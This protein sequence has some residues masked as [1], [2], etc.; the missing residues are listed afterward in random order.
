MS[1]LFQGT[2][3]HAL[4]YFLLTLNETT[5]VTLH[6]LFHHVRKWQLHVELHDFRQLYVLRLGRVVEMGLPTLIASVRFSQNNHK[7]WAKNVQL[8][9][10][11][12]RMST[13]R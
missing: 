2:Q 7:E 11:I 5:F 9:T 6:D 10:L 4:A 12:F 3:I 8:E 13:I 1:A